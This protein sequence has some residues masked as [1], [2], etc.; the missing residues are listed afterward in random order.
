MLSHRDGA[1]LL[2]AGPSP[3]SIDSL[4]FIDRLIG[5]LR[6]GG[7]SLHAAAYGA[8]TIVSYVTGFTLQEQ[9]MQQADLPEEEHDGELGESL[10]QTLDPAMMPNLVDWA[11]HLSLDREPPFAAG[12]DV[13]ING[14]RAE[15][16]T[17]SNTS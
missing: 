17:S 5:A 8:D 12:I 7:A 4:A 2:A 13:I 6:S 1:R 3:L 15:L 9:H 11:P 14:L 10:A 16:A